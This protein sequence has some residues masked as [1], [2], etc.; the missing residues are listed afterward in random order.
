MRDEICGCHFGGLPGRCRTE[1]SP[2]GKGLFCP[3]CDDAP[4]HRHCMGCGTNAVPITFDPIELY[5]S[6]C[7]A[8]DP[9]RSEAK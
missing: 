2:G 3:Y 9:R 8:G 6:T 7:R 5:C 4:F 1:L